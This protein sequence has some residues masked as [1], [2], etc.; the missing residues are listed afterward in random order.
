METWTIQA[1]T[2]APKG[3]RRYAAKGKEF[4]VAGLLSLARGRDANHN[5]LPLML[6]FAAD[7]GVVRPVL[8]NIQLGATLGGFGTKKADFTGRVQRVGD[9]ISV[10]TLCKEPMFVLDPGPVDP[11]SPIEFVSMTDAPWRASCGL[12]EAECLRAA[13]E[14]LQIGIDTPGALRVDDYDLGLEPFADVLPYGDN[15]RE[16]DRELYARDPRA[17]LAG[18]VPAACHAIVMLDY[19]VAAP[20]MEGPGFALY[21][22]T[23]LLRAGSARLPGS[24]SLLFHAEPVLGFDTPCV[25]SCSYDVA[26]A[27]VGAAARE[28][29]NV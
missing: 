16:G 11:E 25:V 14:V 29:I 6:V 12:T 18:I 23:H 7:D 26:M 10:V 28:Y 5:R 24:D 17:Y 13:D 15:R 27:H 9:G 2:K 19:R 4:S 8:A 20:V 21:L 1:P 22:F 3:R